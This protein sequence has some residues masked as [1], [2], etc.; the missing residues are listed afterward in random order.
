MKKILT[1]NF[2]FENF[3]WSLIFLLQNHFLG[4]R[5]D[6]KNMSKIFL[7][8]IF[9]CGNF[10]WSKNLLQIH[11]LGKSLDEK[12]LLKNI[13][14]RKFLCRKIISSERVWKKKI[15]VT[16]VWVENFFVAKPFPRK[17]F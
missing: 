4:N 6:E 15:L 9:F 2:L 3:F 5:L 1:K 13:F 8:E 12:I 14:G 17:T 10:F 7:V 11:F 16:N